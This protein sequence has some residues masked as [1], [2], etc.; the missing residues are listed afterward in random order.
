[1][2]IILHITWFVK[3]SQRWSATLLTKS[4]SLCEQDSVLSHGILPSIQ[5]G[6]ATTLG[7][8]CT[9]LGKPPY[10]WDSNTNIEDLSKVIWDRQM[11]VAVGSFCHCRN[12]RGHLHVVENRNLCLPSPS[13]TLCALQTGLSN[14]ECF[15]T[16]QKNRGAAPCESGLWQDMLIK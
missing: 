12:C 6:L 8:T 1:M 5:I 9:S 4:R 3:V 16:T 7:V 10:G 15:I 2:F 14:P 11:V 13:P